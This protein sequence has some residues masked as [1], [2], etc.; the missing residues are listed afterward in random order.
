MCVCVC[1]LFDYG[2]DK[3]M[4]GA[5]LPTLYERDIWKRLALREPRLDFR[6]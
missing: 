1:V 2:M 4:L 5:S 6:V 3:E